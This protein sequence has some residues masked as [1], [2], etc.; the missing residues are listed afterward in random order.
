[1]Y[2]TQEIKN[3]TD[4]VISKFDGSTTRRQQ[5]YGTTNWQSCQCDQVDNY[6][7]KHA[8]KIPA[9]SPT[10]ESGVGGR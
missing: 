10:D 8:K 4:A 7:D 3:D 6:Q 2:I 1:M 5:K 9:G